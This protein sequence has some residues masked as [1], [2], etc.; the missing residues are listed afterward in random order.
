M[1]RPAVTDDVL[2]A[3]CHHYTQNTQHSYGKQDTLNIIWKTGRFR[4][5]ML[6][7]EIFKIASHKVVGYSVTR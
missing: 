5:K 7:L 2:S 3:A 1:R 6:D 4:S